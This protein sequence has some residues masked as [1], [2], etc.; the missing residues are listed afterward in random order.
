MSVC[1]S[2]FVVFIY[3][4]QYLGSLIFLLTAQSDLLIKIKCFMCI[5]CKYDP[6][7]IV[8]K[9]FTYEKSFYLKLN[10]IFYFIYSDVYFTPSFSYYVD[11]MSL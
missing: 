7:M 10:H 5:V 9:L 6:S 3:F 1:S 8:S 4:I 2:R 11:C